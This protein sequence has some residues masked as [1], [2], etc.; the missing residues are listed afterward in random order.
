[1]DNVKDDL[2]SVIYNYSINPKSTNN[3]I[4]LYGPPGIGKT[5]LVKSFADNA[6]LPF[7]QLSVGNINDS[8]Y[9][10]GHT[11]TYQHS[12]CGQIAK[13]V[14]R[15]GYKTG[16]L[17]LDEID[18]VNDN[19]NNVTGTLM[20][21]CDFTQNDHFTDKYL[22]YDIPIDVSNYLL[23]YSLNDIDKMNKALLSRIGQN[24]IK[25][26]DYSLED[27]I[28]MAKTFIIPKFLKEFGI[29][30]DHIM[31]TESI[32]IYIINDCVSFMNGSIRKVKAL[33][34]KI[35]RVIQYYNAIELPNFSYPLVVSQEIVGFIL[36]AK[37]DFSTKKYI[38]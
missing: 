35:I 22:G 30:E 5:A 25:I 10:I 8:S 4:A 19:N 13:S 18:K 32:L 9:L 6:G 12:E 28:I 38:L 15:M 29:S 26:D 14:M 2:L 3:S 7:A 17:F 1:M 20:H 11:Y 23:V 31:F 21:L 16:I 24:I 34:Y 33:L 27:K 36:N 37:N